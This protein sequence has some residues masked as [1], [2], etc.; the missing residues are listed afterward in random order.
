MLAVGRAYEVDDETTG[1]N[2]WRV[3]YRMR[4]HLN[5]HPFP[6]QRVATIL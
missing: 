2:D 6:T 3:V 1:L 5:A 4:P